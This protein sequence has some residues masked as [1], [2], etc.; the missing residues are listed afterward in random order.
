MGVFG[1]VFPAFFFFFFFFWVF[2]FFFFFFFFVIFFVIFFCYEF[3][4][5]ARPQQRRRHGLFAAERLLKGQYVAP[6]GGRVVTRRQV[7][8]AEMFGRAGKIVTVRVP[9][10]RRHNEYRLLSIDAADVGS[11]ASF[12]SRAPR[13]LAW[14]AEEGERLLARAVARI[15]ARVRRD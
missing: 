4:S 15:A 10:D 9:V 6:Y 1:F 11:K 13:G 7:A 3:H 12:V 2:F 14:T 8:L 5:S